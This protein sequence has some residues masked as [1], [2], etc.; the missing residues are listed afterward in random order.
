MTR[1]VGW[2]TCALTYPGFVCVRMYVYMY[3]CMYMCMC[4][5][6]IYISIVMYVCVGFSQFLFLCD[7]F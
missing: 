1:E 2:V 5:M 7:I 4:V 6:Y 3:L